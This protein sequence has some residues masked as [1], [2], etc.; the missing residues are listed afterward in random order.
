MLWVAPSRGRMSSHSCDVDRVAASVPAVLRRPVTTGASV[1]RTDAG[2]CLCRSTVCTQFGCVSVSLVDRPGPKPA[3]T[4][5]TDPDQPA[6]TLCPSRG[7]EA[8]STGAATARGDSAACA[9]CSLSRWTVVSGLCAV[10]VLLSREAS[11]D[12][13]AGRFSIVATADI[14]AF[15]VAGPETPPCLHTARGSVFDTTRRW[16]MA[17]ARLLAGSSVS[18]LLLDAVSAGDT[19]PHPS[20]RWIHSPPLINA[21]Q[22]GARWFCAAAGRRFS[23][24]LVSWAANRWFGVSLDSLPSRRCSRRLCWHEAHT[25]KTATVRTMPETTAAMMAWWRTTGCRSASSSVTPYRSNQCRQQM[26]ETAQKLF[27]FLH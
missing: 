14:N 2:L 13:D 7:G 25:A 11:V 9:R 4:G 18:G 15:A 21:V 17:A 6:R 3:T 27:A 22:P 5:P 10:G 24:M 26:W 8:A 16:S 23:S 1:Q 20:S 19:A 12:G